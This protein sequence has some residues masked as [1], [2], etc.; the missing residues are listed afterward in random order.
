MGECDTYCT[1]HAAAVARMN[2]DRA[3]C[4]VPGQTASAR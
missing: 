4:P 2:E 3:A 1:V